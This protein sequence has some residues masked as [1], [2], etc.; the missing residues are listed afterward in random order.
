MAIGALA[1]ALSQMKIIDWVKDKFIDDQG[2]Q[3]SSFIIETYDVLLQESCPIEVGKMETMLLKCTEHLGGQGLLKLERELAYMIIQEYMHI[4]LKAKEIIEHK[5]SK[6]KSFKWIFECEE[7]IME[8]NQTVEQ[9]TLG[10]F[11]QV[12]KPFLNPQNLSMP[13]LKDTIR[14]LT[15]LKQENVRWEDEPY[16]QEHQALREHLV[17]QLLNKLSPYIEGAKTYLESQLELNGES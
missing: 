3:S 10:P 9:G 11:A 14:Y 4:Y 5:K 13:T 12:I 16:D 15:H 7:L 17:I 1:E 8:V 2:T 6:D